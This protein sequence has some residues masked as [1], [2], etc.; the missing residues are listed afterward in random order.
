MQVATNRPVLIITHN[1]KF[2]RAVKLSAS[3]AAKVIKRV[4]N[5]IQKAFTDQEKVEPTDVGGDTSVR[6]GPRFDN[7]GDSSSGTGEGQEAESEV[8]ADVG[9]TGDTSEATQKDE[10]EGELG[11]PAED[12]SPVGSSD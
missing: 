5:V 6:G 9:D 11:R 8:S 10:E 1:T 2:M 4:E 7:D 12:E 3:E